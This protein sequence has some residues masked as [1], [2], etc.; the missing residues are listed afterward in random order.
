[1]IA[2]T[3]MALDHYVPQVHLRKFYNSEK[4]GLIVFDKQNNKSAIRTAKQV[5]RIG[6]G[7]TN[8]YLTE[9]RAI[10]E[11]LKPVENGYND[12][13][14]ALENGEI[15]GDVVYA[16]SG[17]AAYITTCSPAAIR[18]Q[19]AIMA[20]IVTNTTKLADAKGIFPD[21]PGILPGDSVTEL[22]EN[23]AIKLE[24]DGKY[25]QA[26][27]I[28]DIQDRVAA[29]GNFHWDILINN[30]AD[31]PFFTSDYPVAIDRNPATDALDRTFPLTPSLAIRINPDR[32]IKRIGFDLRFR[33]FTQSRRNLSRHEVVDINRKLVQ[34]AE[35][36]VFSNH[37][38]EWVPNFIA[39]NRNYRIEISQI[40]HLN[41]RGM[42]MV[43]N[44]AIVP[45]ARKPMR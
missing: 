16:I 37:E 11:F 27:G 40:A 41:D 32:N 15:T 30:H 45:F 21:P 35:R 44:Q 24:I 10:E 38:R 23:E 43:T 6:E 14:A 36:L 13:V 42:M 26:I 17:F 9:P 34:G 20:G 3:T 33:Q 7:N 1:M 25:P 19:T 29:F 8:E 12:A 39:K 4:A 22:L 28:M 5:C 18:M 31:A 2:F